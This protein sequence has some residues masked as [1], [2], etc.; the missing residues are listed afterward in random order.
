MARVTPL[1]VIFPLTTHSTEAQLRAVARTLYIRYTV[2]R[3][4]NGVM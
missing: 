1:L 4:V 2:S 3:H